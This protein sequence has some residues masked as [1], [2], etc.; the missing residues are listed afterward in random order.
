MILTFSLLQFK[1]SIQAGLKITTIREDKKKRWKPS[2]LIHFWLHNPRNK[3]RYPVGDPDRPHEFGRG[4]VE[5]IEDIE[6]Y[7]KKGIIIISGKEG[8]NVYSHT[9]MRE[10][11]LDSIA[12]DDGF[13][14]WR[15]M[16][17]WFNEDFKGRRIHFKY[18]QST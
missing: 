13:T 18:V 1:A 14:N 2:G 16:K 7:P 11:D 9:Y 15:Q 12:V 4:Y 17:Q 5:F 6:I 10:P 3:W 8:D